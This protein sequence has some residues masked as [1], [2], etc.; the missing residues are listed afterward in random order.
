MDPDDVR[1][2]D[3]SSIVGKNLSVEEKYI[4]LEMEPCQPS[5]SYLSQRKKSTMRCCSQNVFYHDEKL[6]NRWKWI[7]YSKSKDALFCILCLLFSDSVSRGENQRLNQGNA[8]TVAGFANWN[9]QYTTVPNHEKNAIHQ[10]A[11]ISHALFNF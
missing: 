11:V 3:P 9:K 6:Q 4:L 1:T 10:E 7:S 5:M 2:F 8:F